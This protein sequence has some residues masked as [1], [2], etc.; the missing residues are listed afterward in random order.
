MIGIDAGGTKLLGGVVDEQLG[1]EHRVHRLWLGEGVGRLLDIMVEVVAE[2]RDAAPDVEAVGFGIPSLIDRRTG[3][4]VVSPHLPLD[5]V[6]FR[7]LMAE[8]L[9]MPVTVDNDSNCAV[10]AEQRHGAAQGASEVAMITLGTGIG[11]GLVVGGEVYRGSTGT[12]AEF[13]HMTVDLDGPECP[14]G[15]PNRG[16][17]EAVASGRAIG[18]AGLEAARRRPRSALGRAL[19]AGEEV[20][21]A[22]VTELAHDGDPAAEAVLEQIGARLGVGLVNLAN[23]L[24][25]EVIVVGGGAV[26]AGELLVGPARRTLAERALGPNR[27]VRVALAHF[28]P[29]AGMLGA[30]LM[31]LEAGA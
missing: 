31:A 8:R 17:L 5:G 3:I 7:D 21:G 18:V 6:P 27:D 13:G 9:G 25:P 14:S 1:V 15:C 22:L 24:N 28:G 23:L 19:A 29:E 26:A 16:C 12:G 20:T 4:S 10:L 2:A 30:A 11:G